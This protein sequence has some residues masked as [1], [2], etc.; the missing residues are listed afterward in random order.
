MTCWKRA[1][2]ERLAYALA[3]LCTIFMIGAGPAN[4]AGVQSCGACEPGGPLGGIE[5]LISGG[6]R[7]P[8]CQISKISPSDQGGTSSVEIFAYSK[9]HH[10]DT[11]STAHQGALYLVLLESTADAKYLLDLAR[12]TPSFVAG[13]RTGK[14]GILL[15]TG[16]SP[17][18]EY[19]AALALRGHARLAF[20]NP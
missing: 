7:T 13:W 11:R 5:H 17:V 16:T 2:C 10:C 4:A 6:G 9:T 14:V 20:R 19:E 18:H 15:G 8:L 3:I 12:V 1:F